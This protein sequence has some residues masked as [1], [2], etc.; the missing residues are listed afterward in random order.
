M[1]LG[2]LFDG[3]GGFPLAGVLNGIE[4]IW[5]SEIE[6]Y[7]LRVTAARFPKMKQLGDVMKIDGSKVD[8]V[9][10]IT[11]GSP[12]QDL[13]VAGKQA[14]IHDG[15]RSSLFFEA[16][17][18]IREMRKA[19]DGKYPTYAVWENV[20]GAFSSNRGEDFK[21]VLQAFCS[22][23]RGGI[24]VP[25]SQ[26]GKWKHAGCIV[27]DGFSVAW[28]QYDAQFWGVPQ[29]RK[30][31]YLI[32]DFADEC[33]GEILFEP[34]SMRRHHPESSE[35]RETAAGFIEGS[36][37]G[38]NLAFAWANSAGAGL[39]EGETAPTIKANRNG[40][41]AVAY[42][43]EGHVIDRNTGQNGKGYAEGY[44]HTL[45]ATDRHGVVCLNDQGGSK[46]G[47][48]DKAGCLRA[49]E[50]GHQPI[51]CYAPEGNHCGSYREDDTSATLQ[52]KY[53]YG[54]GGD[55][56]LVI[57]NHP[58]DSRCDFAKDNVVPTL[59]ARIGTGGGNVP[60]ILEK[61]T[62]FG[63]GQ[64]NQPIGDVA[65]ALNCMHD[66]QSVCYVQPAFGDFR[67]SEIAN[68][69]K[70]SDGKRTDPGACVLE[71]GKT[72]RKYIVRR[73]TPLECCRLQGFPDWWCDG[74]EGSDSAQYRMWGNG[75]ALP[76]AFDVLERI[77]RHGG[78]HEEEKEKD[79]A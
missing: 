49:Q 72:E 77:V 69:L 28:R 52:T 54:G 7:P 22:L 35:A 76:C 55:A 59:T 73:L 42:S 75:I 70:A 67:E 19:T 10:I 47:V 14:G 34:E 46:M 45:N 44:A 58:D 40:E 2:S 79:Q 29:R 17:R 27:G 9:D 1:T 13:S 32:A 50:H 53:H 41:P 60:M 5:A 16:I 43:I 71:E 39:S 62:C 36:A 57:E 24:T 74:V 23:T 4:P 31:I 21:A 78:K 51:V 63:N 37:G 56:A 8:P 30:R 68:T 6:P 12:C 48:S 18:I 20:P 3:S 38:S 66:Q 33:A 61:V 64:T 65:G 25:G 26:G 15:A 11:F